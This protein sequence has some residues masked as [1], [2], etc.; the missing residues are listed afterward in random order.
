MAAVHVFQSGPCPG[1]SD[2]TWGPH[3]LAACK[4]PRPCA[5]HLAG[6][7]VLQAQAGQVVGQL[8]PCQVKNRIPGLMHIIQMGKPSLGD[9]HHFPKVLHRSQDWNLS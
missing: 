9:T 1:P 5:H 6:D 8:L 3:K 2:V 4:A 7:S